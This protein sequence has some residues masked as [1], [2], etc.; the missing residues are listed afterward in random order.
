VGSAPTVA[1]CRGDV[2]RGEGVTDSILNLTEE[3]EMAEG[4][5]I[6]RASAQGDNG[7]EKLVSK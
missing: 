7:V 1:A 5:L 4:Q 6:G 3:R 2:G